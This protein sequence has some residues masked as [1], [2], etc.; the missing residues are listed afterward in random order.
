MDLAFRPVPQSI[1]GRATRSD[2]A[3]Q[4][5]PPPPSPHRL[6]PQHL[7]LPL[8]SKAQVTRSPVEKLFTVRPAATEKPTSWLISPGSLPMPAF[9]PWSMFVHSCPARFSPQHLSNPLSSEAQ[10]KS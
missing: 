2:A 5:P 1:N 7:T 6:A 10:L 8:S 4:L 3:R 9:G